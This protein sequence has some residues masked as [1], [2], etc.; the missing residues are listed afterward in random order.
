MSKRTRHSDNSKRQ[1]PVQQQR[2]SAARQTIGQAKAG[3]RGDPEAA[4]A[5]PAAK[6]GS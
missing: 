3:K 2:A 1:Q 4:R 6:S 5:Q